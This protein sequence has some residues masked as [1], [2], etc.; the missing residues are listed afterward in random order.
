MQKIKVLDPVTIN[1]IAAGEVIERPSSAV[2]ELIENSLDA[3]AERIHI[4]IES[5]GKQLI[6]VSDNGTGISKKDL[7]L[8]PVQYATSK[9]NRLE[10]IYSST[11]FGFRGEALA[12]ICHIAKLEILSKTKNNNAYKITANK[13]KISEPELTSHNQGTTIIIKDMFHEIPVRR[14]F[15]K[16]NNTETSYIYDIVQQ[17][18]LINPDVSFTLISNKKEMINTTGITSQKDLLIMFFGKEL[19]GKLITVDS[20]IDPIKFKGHISDPTLT[21]SNRSKQFISVNNRLVK[22]A[23]LLKAVT[24]SY[25]DQIP[26][27]KFPLVL[28]NLTIPQNLIDVNIHPQKT[29]IKYL[30]PGFLFDTFPRVIKAN[31]RKDLSILLSS[32]PGTAPSIESPLLSTAKNTELKQKPLTLKEAVPQEIEGQKQIKAASI[33][34]EVY[35]SL[36]KKEEISDSSFEFLQLFDTYLIIKTCDGLWILDQHAAHERVLYEK[37]ISEKNKDVIKQQLLISETISLTADLYLIFLENKNKIDDLG[38][39]TEDFGNNQVVIRSVP[40]E[41]ININSGL[42]VTDILENIKTSKSSSTPLENSMKNQL[43]M[44][45]CKAAVKAGRKMTITETKA[46]INSLITTP[47]NYTCP[48]GR[49]LFIKLE[50]DQIERM[51]LRR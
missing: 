49:P 18:S 45:A 12:S 47:S 42:V 32:I 36:F 46:L 33:K 40:Q 1:K 17:F 28:L 43:Q 23:V 14:K 9:I 6:R 30:N 50:K 44:A 2:K 10:D 39:E 13:D 48:H 34:P 5:G 25:L 31:L 21:F 51:F 35:E 4:E 22:S 29:D 15:L 7:R 16:A 24:Q 8:A 27:K 41:F 37:L 38:F 3:G 20:C 26:D 19:N 11:G